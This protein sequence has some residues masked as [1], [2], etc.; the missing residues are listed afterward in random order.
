MLAMVRGTERKEPEEMR[1]VRTMYDTT[2]S[3]NWLDGHD[4]WLFCFRKLRSKCSSPPPVHP[5]LLRS[6]PLPS[7][8]WASKDP[9]TRN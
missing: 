9:S 2:V 8:R 7:D 3:L 6:I 1:D 5:H 4:S